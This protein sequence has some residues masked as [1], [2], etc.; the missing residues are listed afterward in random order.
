MTANYLMWDFKQA[1]PIA[2][3]LAAQ[4]MPYDGPHAAAV[5]RI[6]GMHFKYHTRELIGIDG[7]RPPLHDPAMVIGLWSL[8]RQDP[9][10]LR[11]D[12]RI[13]LYRQVFP[14]RNP[15]AD[16]VCALGDGEGYRGSAW[17]SQ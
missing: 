14:S 10:P 17:F 1:V 8:G 7:W 5:E 3:S 15:Q 11:L 9:L 6:L 2:Q 12:E 4:P 13:A 16:C